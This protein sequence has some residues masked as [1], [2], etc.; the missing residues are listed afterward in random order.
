M[1]RAQPAVVLASF[2][3]TPRESLPGGAEL[4]G[5]LCSLAACTRLPAVGSHIEAPMAL[6]LQ[7]IGVWGMLPSGRK[8]LVLWEAEFGCDP[9]AGTETSF[10]HDWFILAAQRKLMSYFLIS[11]LS[12]WYT[13][14]LDVFAVLGQ[15]WSSYR[16][17]GTSTASSYTVLRVA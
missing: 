12:H 14:I 3:A 16:G 10:R 5:P 4:T 15:V 13:H 2:R 1:W 11:L 7:T 17:I 8:S 6:S 9:S